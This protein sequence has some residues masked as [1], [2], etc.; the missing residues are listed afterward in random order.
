MAIPH[1]EQEPVSPA[2][3]TSLIEFD[4]DTPTD[5]IF[6]EYITTDRLKLERLDTSNVQPR[7]LYQVLAHDDEIY[8][9]TAHTLWTP[10]RTP[11]ETLDRFETAADDW[12]SGE[13][14]QYVI[15]PH[16][17]EQG[18]DGDTI[19]GTTHLTVDWE[20]QVGEM[21]I[22]LRKKFWGREYSAERAHAL[23]HV[24]FTHL[25]LSVVEV[26][27]ITNNTRSKRAIEKYVT[28]FNGQKDGCLRNYY[29]A[30]GGSQQFDAHQFSITREEYMQATER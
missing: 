17:T 8:E 27:C 20:R 16:E 13:Q 15:K 5:S 28:E 9:A 6:P 30:Y 25:D 23:L 18:S 1:R 19:A 21:G 22:F 3:F 11:R 2:G 4:D 10:H 12:K 7:D 26:R 24:S 14:A 29:G